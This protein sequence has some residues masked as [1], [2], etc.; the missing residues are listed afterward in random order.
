MIKKTNNNLR[1]CQFCTNNVTGVDYKDVELLKNY[2]DTHMRIN[3]HRKTGVCAKHQRSLANAIKRA[4]E[5]GL[6]PYLAG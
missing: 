6:L 1:Q 5:L 2:L 4:R 3:K